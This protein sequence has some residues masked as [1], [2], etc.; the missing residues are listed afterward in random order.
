VDASHGMSPRDKI[1]AVIHDPA[2]FSVNVHSTEFPNGAIRGQ[3]G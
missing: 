2:N 1:Q 3:L